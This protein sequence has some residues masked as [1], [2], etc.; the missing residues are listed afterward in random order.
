MNAEEKKLMN[1]MVLG[2]HE[3][4]I[5]D[6]AQTRKN[7][8]TG[9]LL[10]YTRGQVFSGEEAFKSGLVDDL[11]G[12]W[13]AGRKIHEELDL[14]ADFGLKFLK[15]KKKFDWSTF[16]DDMEDEAKTFIYNMFANKGA[17]PMFLYQ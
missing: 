15:K 8:I 14:E 6:I 3:Q 12:L 2:V 11:A 1:K 9:D 13:P 7:K 10:D 4:F 16:L 17:T 5:N